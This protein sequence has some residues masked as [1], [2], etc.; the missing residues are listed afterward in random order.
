[1]SAKGKMDGRM[2]VSEPVHSRCAVYPPQPRRPATRGGQPKNSRSG[3][4][5]THPGGSGHQGLVGG[6]SQ[7]LRFWSTWENGVYG[8]RRLSQDSRISALGDAAEKG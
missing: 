6:V 8:P 1:M 7:I 5:G 2:V 3:C 4:L